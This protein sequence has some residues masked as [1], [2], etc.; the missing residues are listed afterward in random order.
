MLKKLRH[1]CFTTL[2]VTPLLLF[3]GQ[4]EDIQL[5]DDCKDKTPKNL[6]TTDNIQTV[7]LYYSSNCGW[8]LKVLKWMECA[9]FRVCMKDIDTTDQNGKRFYRNELKSIARKS[10]NEEKKALAES[11]RVMVPCLIINGKPLWESSHIICWL[12]AYKNAQDS[13]KHN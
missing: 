9:Q 1:I 5:C 4:A 3:A 13:A 8:S 10:D 11:D 12:R 2:I 7:E 6:P